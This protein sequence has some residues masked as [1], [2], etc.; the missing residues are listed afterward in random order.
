M[1][2]AARTAQNNRFDEQY[3][4][5]TAKLNN[6]SACV[7]VTF[8]YISLPFPAKQHIKCS[9]YRFC[10]EQEHTRVNFPVSV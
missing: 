9:N 7:C 3:S 1:G 2:M 6:A 10:G 5:S 4:Q 8:W